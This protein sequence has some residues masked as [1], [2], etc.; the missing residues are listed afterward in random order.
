MSSNCCVDFYAIRSIFV[1]SFVIRP[2]NS[3]YCVECVH[4]L[5]TIAC[6]KNPALKMLPNPPYSLL[7]ISTAISIL[8]SSRNVLALNSSISR[9]SIEFVASSSSEELSSGSASQEDL[10]P[11]AAQEYDSVIREFP[12]SWYYYTRMD[13]GPKLYQALPL[14]AGYYEY[15]SVRGFPTGGDSESGLLRQRQG[16]IFVFTCERASVNYFFTSMKLKRV[17]ACNGRAH[18]P[19]RYDF[20]HP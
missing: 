9:S 12:T 15:E 8:S 18:F 3:S 14:P 10:E 5:S 20:S 7:I 19:H 17:H 2:S 1:G 11:S 13:Q 16:T 4:F 6:S